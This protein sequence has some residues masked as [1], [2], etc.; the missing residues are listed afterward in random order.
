MQ[1]TRSP[2]ALT[3]LVV[4]G[5]LIT[6]CAKE[7]ETP[8]PAVAEK[9]ESEH[10][11]KL[12]ETISLSPAAIRAA[13]IKT[14]KVEPL[15]LGNRLTVNGN[16]AFNENRLLAVAAP[17]TGRVVQLPVDL[18]QS[19]E[20]GQPLAWIESV[21]LGRARQEYLR[22]VTD[23]DIAEKS[24]SRA[25]LLAAEK[26]ISASE[27]QQREADYGSKRAALAAAEL[28]LRQFG[29]D[30]G[31]ARTTAIPRVA[32]RAPFS[33]TIID[34]KVTPG[35]LVEAL[36][37]LITVADLG[38]VWVFFQIYDKDLAV[39]HTGLAIHVSSDATPGTSFSGTIDFVG[40]E[41]DPNTRTTR[42]RATVRNERRLL[43]P[44]LFVRGTIDVPRAQVN[45]SVI[46]VP[47]D[48]LQ[49]LENQPTV[50][51]RVA[52][53]QFARR[54]VETGRTF[55]GNVEILRGIKIG[56]E[57]ATEGTFVLKSE[58][59]NAALIEED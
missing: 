13:G 46:A 53:N 32:V 6:A 57:I 34:R 30:P 10:A 22:A 8:A 2:H 31:L 52:Q 14:W 54:I 48:A 19:V 16:V 18:G 9:Q 27:L 28:A 41:V 50:F 49:T 59:S 26:A 58:F 42:V 1:G 36:H 37:P 4:A 5:F 47:Q 29:D 12:P 35:T 44:G 3:L 23:S 25:K 11:E 24:Y 51:V 21:E 33:G 55:D 7:R 17:V 38:T 20:K 40:S 15:D 39:V 45:G 56:D 43:R